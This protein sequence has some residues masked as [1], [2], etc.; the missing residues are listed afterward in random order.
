MS[1]TSKLDD[2]LTALTS[3]DARLQNIETQGG[4]VHT[5]TVAATEWTVI[6]SLGRS[7]GV[8]ATDGA[9]NII[10]FDRG[11]PDFNTTVLTFTSATSGRAVC[12]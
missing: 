9:G 8:F 10:E 2:V 12:S 3:I 7:P 4:Y 5:Q 1:V 6:H 11:D